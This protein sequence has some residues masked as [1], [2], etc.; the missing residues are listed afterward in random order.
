[1]L[2]KLFQ[3]VSWQREISHFS[4]KVCGARVSG[5]SHLLSWRSYWSNT[6]IWR[7]QMLCRSKS[8]M[9]ALVGWDLKECVPSCSQLVTLIT[10]RNSMS[11]LNAAECWD[12][13]VRWW[14]IY[15]HQI[16]LDLSVILRNIG[17][18]HILSIL[19]L[20]GL[21][22]CCVRSVR[23]HCSHPSLRDES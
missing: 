11:S 20:L 5:E 3:N 19:R 15:F 16:F 7:S 21:C 18:L 9:G 23:S 6:R 12:W 14:T 4:Q 1:M 10:P 13:D 8:G 2:L 22:I 17:P